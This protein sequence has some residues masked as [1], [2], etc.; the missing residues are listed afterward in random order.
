ML[1]GGLLRVQD[2]LSV[3]AHRGDLP[4]LRRALAIESGFRLLDVGG[5]TGAYTAVFGQGAEEIAVLEPHEARVRYGRQR[6][7]HLRFVSAPAEAIPF[8]DDHFDRVT[9]IVSFHHVQE[10]DRALEEIRRVL[11][12]GGRFVVEEFDPNHGR[13]RRAHAFERT[14]G[15]DQSIFYTPDELRSKLEGHG[16]GAIAHEM[17]GPGYL[18]TAEA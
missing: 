8:P 4:S 10:P 9:T 18:M 3:R 15:G 17:V 14:F 5:G 7:P 2:W 1:R 16:F 6:R 12:A 11:K 13:G